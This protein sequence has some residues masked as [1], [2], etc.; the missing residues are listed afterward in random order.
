MNYTDVSRAVN[1]VHLQNMHAKNLKTLIEIKED[2]HEMKSRIMLRTGRSSARRDGLPPQ[3]GLSINTFSIR[4]PGRY[5]PAD[6]K[7]YMK[8]K[9][10]KIAKTSQTTQF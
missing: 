5:Q 3:A 10:T 2:P 8:S 7:S 1:L 4:I 9:G 6:S